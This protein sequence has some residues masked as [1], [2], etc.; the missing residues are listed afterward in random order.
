M[1]MTVD[2]INVYFQQRFI[3]HLYDFSISAIPYLKLSQ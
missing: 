3:V 1:L 2:R